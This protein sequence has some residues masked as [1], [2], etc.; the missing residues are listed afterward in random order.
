LLLGLEEAELVV[1]AADAESEEAAPAER[2]ARTAKRRTAR[3]IG[4]RSMEPHGDKIMRM[5]TVS[6]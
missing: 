6:R 4:V 5:A 3:R 1:A 2:A